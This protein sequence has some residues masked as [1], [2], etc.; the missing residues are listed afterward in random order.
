MTGTL[1]GLGIGPGDPELITL[2]AL[3]IIEKTPIIAYPAPDVGESLARAIA[4]PHIPPG[5]TEINMRMPMIP[6]Q[7]PAHNVY[8]RYA[9]EISFHLRKNLDVTVLCE[10]DPFLYGSFMYLFI[11]LSNKFPTCVVPGVS[12][13]GASAAAIGVP[14]VSRNETLSIVPGP[15]DEIELIDRINSSQAVAVM[16]VGRHF[17]KVCRVINRLGL[18]QYAH[19][20]EHAS[21]SNQI[22]LNLDQVDAN[23][24]PYFSMILIRRPKEGHD[25]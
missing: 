6:G 20:V 11:R 18:N 13:L 19:Y 17:K 24:V 22:T 7:F 8:D 1:Y 14:L 3:R 10:G 4:A 25:L 16:K 23:K 9:D 12:S 5:K 21:M 2:K 15:L